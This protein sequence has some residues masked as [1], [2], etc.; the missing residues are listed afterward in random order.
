MV[1]NHILTGD[2]MSKIKMILVIIMLLI[3]ESCD[4]HYQNSQAHI[5]CLEDNKG[6]E[7]YC[8]NI[9]SKYPQNTCKPIKY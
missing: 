1:T 4:C 2:T 3:I 9:K 7:Q 6:N 5:K 8:I